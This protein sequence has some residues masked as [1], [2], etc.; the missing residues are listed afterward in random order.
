MKHDIVIITNNGKPKIRSILDR[1]LDEMMASID[2]M[3]DDISR[4]LGFPIEP[5]AQISQENPSDLESDE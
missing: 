3:S 5:N 4:E 2:A 1:L